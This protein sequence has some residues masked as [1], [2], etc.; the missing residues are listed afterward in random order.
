MRISANGSWPSSLCGDSGGRG[1]VLFISLLSLGNCP[2][3]EDLSF[4]SCV[5][6][7]SVDVRQPVSQ[8]VRQSA[9]RLCVLKYS[10]GCGCGLVECTAFDDAS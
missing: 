3:R 6:S 5:V 2:R 9:S 4:S 10:R 8:S 1:K 7:D